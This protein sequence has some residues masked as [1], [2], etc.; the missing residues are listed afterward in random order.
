MNYKEDIKKPERKRGHIVE[1]I[2]YNPISLSDKG[3]NQACDDWE[4]YLSAIGEKSLREII[5]RYLYSDDEY[6]L[7]MPENEKIKSIL[8]E[9]QAHYK[10]SLQE[11][12]AQIT[13]H[14]ACHSAEHNPAEGKLHGC[15]VVCGVPFPCQYAGNPPNK[16]R[17]L[18]EEEIRKVMS[19]KYFLLLLVPFI[20]IYGTIKRLA[21]IIFKA[22]EEKLSK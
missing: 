9:I 19:P 16:A 21:H 13:A 3:Y 4:K 17:W 22:Q 6:Y 20:G 2:G 5:E 10:A 18:S 8:E 1:G 15:C 11:R 12:I 7:M 14:R